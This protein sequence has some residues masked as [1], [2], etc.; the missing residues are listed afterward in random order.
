MI[1]TDGY[2]A[3]GITTPGAA[4]AEDWNTNP[5]GTSIN[6]AYWDD[7]VYL[8]EYTSG[9]KSEK[10]SMTIFSRKSW[11]GIG[12]FSSCSGTT[13]SGELDAK[14]TTS[15]NST[16]TVSTIIAPSTTVYI[17]IGQWGTPNGLDFDVIDFSVSTCFIPEN[18][19]NTSVTTTTG[20]FSWD[21]EA[22]ATTGYNWV[23]MADGDDPMVD[24]PIANG[25][26]APGSTT[27][28]VTG[29][30]SNTDYD[31]YVQSD[32]GGGDLSNWSSVVSFL[33]N[34]SV[35]LAPVTENFNDASNL[36]CWVEADSGIP[37]AGPSGLGSSA[38]VIDDF[39]N[40]NNY[41]DAFRVNLF[42]D[43]KEEW[44]ISPEIDLASNA[45]YL[46][47]FVA[48]TDS[49]NSS[50]NED[51]GMASTDDEVQ[52]LITTD[53]GSTWQNLTT[54]NS[55]NVPPLA[56]KQEALDLSSYS[57]VIQIA[58]WASEGTN[59]DDADYDFFH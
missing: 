19:Q 36:N 7:D 16:K 54:Y 51:G 2:T 31:F 20:D 33:T 58:F 46:K 49:N 57:G 24:T 18:V 38:W 32:C 3:N 15:S 55:A 12:I 14:G 5:T 21:S 17:A 10:I 50:A 40:N 41:T 23:V 29:L 44:L 53:G 35:F 37:S 34:C 47:Y 8:F 43:S 22:T 28:N 4:G 25:S 52:V 39:L 13:F 26:V 48:E 59:N 42:S 9:T 45:Y 11:N 6:G 27:V 56:G 30:S 1:L